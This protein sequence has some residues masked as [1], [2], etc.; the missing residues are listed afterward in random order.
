[1][2]SQQDLLMVDRNIFVAK[3]SAGPRTSMEVDR[4]CTSAL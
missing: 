3:T 2:D 1:M 4:S